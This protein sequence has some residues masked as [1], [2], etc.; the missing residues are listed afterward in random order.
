[1]Q[2]SNTL[3]ARWENY[4]PSKTTWFWSVVGTAVVTTILG[5]T[6]GGWTTSGNAAVMAKK[7]ATDA[8]A[9]LAA[10]VCVDRFAASADA[11]QQLTVLKEKS[12]WERDDFIKEG[13][14]AKL[15]G[16]KRIISGAADRCADMLAGMEELPQVS[17]VV[18]PVD[19]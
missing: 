14:W 1:M 17:A 18:R 15:L 12:T 3:S 5:F 16:P 6:A 11:S 10:T 7:A 19:G 9:E 13:G 2:E 8:R 4:R